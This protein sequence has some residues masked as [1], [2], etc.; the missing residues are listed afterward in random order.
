LPDLERNRLRVGFFRPAFRF[1][2]AS[3]SVRAKEE[4]LLHLAFVEKKMIHK[5]IYIY[6]CCP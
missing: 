2:T 3:A 1:C 4:P 6:F 5:W